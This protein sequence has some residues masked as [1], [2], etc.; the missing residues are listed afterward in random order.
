MSGLW[1]E[2]F[3]LMAYGCT[4]SGKTLPPPKLGLVRRIPLRINGHLGRCVECC[5]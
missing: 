5:T 1:E 2:G 4:L 3:A